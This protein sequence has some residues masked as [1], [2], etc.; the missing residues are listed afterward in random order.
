M[1]NV[2]ERVAQAGRLK[3]D[4]ASDLMS[5]STS[6]T[7]D[8][9]LSELLKVMPESHSPSGWGTV[10]NNEAWG[11]ASGDPW[12]APAKQPQERPNQT[13]RWERGEPPF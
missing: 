10:D 2:L 9:W 7:Q 13:P 6:G 12:G 5:D 3:P 8:R 11:A 1:R 4:E